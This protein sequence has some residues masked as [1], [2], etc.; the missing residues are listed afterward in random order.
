M[1]EPVNARDHVA[2]GTAFHA[3]IAYLVY[4]VV[5]PLL[6]LVI[7]V[8]TYGIALIGGLIALILHRS[9]QRKAE[10]LL[11]GSSLC[12]SEH[13]FPEIH[14]IA[15]EQ[16]A[17]L[18][19]AHL[20]EVFILE[21]SEQN[22]AALKFGKKHFVLLF[23]DIVFGSFATGNKDALAFIIG[24]ELGHHALGHTGAI[25]GQIRQFW[26]PLS[27]LDEYSCDA[28]GHALCP[29]VQAARDAL[30]LLLIGPQLFKKVNRAA[31][32]EQA[33]EVKANKYSKK[34]E[35]KLTHPLLLNRYARL[36]EQEA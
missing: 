7:I 28:V 12:V 27:R 35:S 24:H 5:M 30:I 34:S 16:A 6:C 31:L 36:I 32:D 23:D 15:K 11:R 9:N 10:A 25:R 26:K 13:Q 33:A 19:L 20:P 18:G 21:A 29:S 1:S 17:R 3:T 2:S 4:L 22:A 8:A 14:Q